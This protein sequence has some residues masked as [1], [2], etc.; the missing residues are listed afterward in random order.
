MQRTCLQ[1]FFVGTIRLMSALHPLTGFLLPARSTLLC[2]PHQLLCEYR[3]HF[4]GG[5]FLVVCGSR[6]EGVLP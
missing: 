1:T 6:R 3:R 2:R 5:M 4:Q